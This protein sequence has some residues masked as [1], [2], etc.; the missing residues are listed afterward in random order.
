[1]NNRGSFPSP[2]E[3]FK[4]SEYFR[5][6]SR[7]SD[8]CDEKCK[9]DF[10]CSMVHL[11]TNDMRDCQTRW[12]KIKLSG[13]ASPIPGK[14][15]DTSDSGATINDIYEDWAARKRFRQQLASQVISY[16]IVAT[17]LIL[18]LVYTAHLG[19]ML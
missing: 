19:P 13:V 10:L 6:L 1:M 7:I 2:G 8:D 17:V 18:I 3:L 15:N 4:K 11:K 9:T 12:A 16:A 5:P 14:G